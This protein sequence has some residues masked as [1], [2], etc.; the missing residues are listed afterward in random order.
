MTTAFT[1]FALLTPALLLLLGGGLLALWWRWRSWTELGWM[2][3]SFASSGLAMLLQVLHWP[4]P[5]PVYVLAFSVCYVGG[6]SAMAQSM[7]VRLGVPMPWKALG[8]LAPLLLGLQLW[9]SAVEPDLARRVYLFTTGVMLVMALPLWQWRRM[10]LHS[11]FDRLLRGVYVACIALHL[12]RTL[13]MLP[14]SA[15]VLTADF[16][17]STFWV[18]VHFCALLCSVA[19]AGCMLVAV[20]WGVIHT[21]QQERQRDALTGVLHRQGFTERVRRL[22]RQGTQRWMLV[23]CE[24]DRWDWVQRHWGSA[25]ANEVLQV[26]A[27]LLQRNVRAGDVVARL[28]GATFAILL[29]GADM[30]TAMPVAERMRREM[31]RLRLPQLV[32][33]RV[34][35]S[36]G[37][38]TVQALDA[39]HLDAAMEAARQLLASAQQAGSNRVRGG[40][41][42]APP[43]MPVEV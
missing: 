1:P 27:Q 7:A 36:M 40:R 39:P 12:L 32:G 42:P 28:E 24:L 43:P 38:S 35:W 15:Q 19:L 22:E 9:Y 20:G 33:E 6:A 21:L 3:G 16:S 37:V 11:R 31:A 23:L 14:L 4:D 26:A 18:V 34:T 30:T 29:Q 17:G 25:V 41:V 2:G 13:V 10:V 8:V 5:L